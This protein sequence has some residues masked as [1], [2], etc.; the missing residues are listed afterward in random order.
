MMILSL[1]L[2]WGLEAPVY[3]IKLSTQGLWAIVPAPNIPPERVP[4]SVCPGPAR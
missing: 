2:L 1:E 3:S 4:Q